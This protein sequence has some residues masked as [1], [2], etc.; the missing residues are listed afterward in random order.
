[1]AWDEFT[2]ESWAV[3]LVMALATVLFIAGF[4]AMAVTRGP[5]QIFKVWALFPW[6]LR[7]SSAIEP[8]FPRVSPWPRPMR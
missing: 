1:M 6:A 4:V 7:F 8:S 2:P 5:R 3:I